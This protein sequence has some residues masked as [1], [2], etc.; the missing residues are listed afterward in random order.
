MKIKF[1]RSI[2]L[3]LAIGAVTVPL[4]SG[5]SQQGQAAEV[6]FDARTDCRIELD[7]SDGST[8]LAY[9]RNTN[10]RMTVQVTVSVTESTFQHGSRR[11][12]DQIHILA[13]GQRTFCGGTNSFNATYTY[14]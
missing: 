12:P 14:A 10:T 11:L 3:A 6:A 9:V 13:P 8:M 4:P 5:I 2:P 1:L 7:R